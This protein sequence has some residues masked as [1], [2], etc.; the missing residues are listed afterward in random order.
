MFITNETVVGPDYKQ[1]LTLL[2]Y[3]TMYGPAWLFDIENLT[4]MLIIN[5]TSF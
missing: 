3:L 2:H 4:I 1:V 5:Q